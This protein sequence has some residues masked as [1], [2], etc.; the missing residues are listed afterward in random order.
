MLLLSKEMTDKDKSMKT[1]LML[2][3]EPQNK[4]SGEQIWKKNGFFKD[5]RAELS[6]EKVNIPENCLIYINQG[7]LSTVKNGE[8]AMYLDNFIIG[9]LIIAANQPKDIE[10]YVC[11]QNEVKLLSPVYELETGQFKGIRK[12]M[13]FIVLRGDSDETFLSYGFDKT[14]SKTLF[15]YSKQQIPNAFVSVAFK[16]H[17]EQIMSGDRDESS[18]L[19]YFLPSLSDRKEEINQYMNNVSLSPVDVTVDFIEKFSENVS[20]KP[21]LLSSSDEKERKPQIEILYGLFKHMATV[22]DQN[23]ERN[24]VHLNLAQGR[25]TMQWSNSIFDSSKFKLTY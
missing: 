22:S 7:F 8:I 18:S 15:S 9:Q 17:F 14:R 21:D 25:H 16:K 19:F 6:L 20:F 5:V 12:Q 23:L 2:K 11:S 1:Q 24:V 13:A 3:S 10:S 4:L